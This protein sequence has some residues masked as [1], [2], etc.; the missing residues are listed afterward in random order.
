M[1]AAD[2]RRSVM[3][4]DQIDPEYAGRHPTHG[5]GGHGD[6]QM[7]DG[8]ALPRVLDPVVTMGAV[9]RYVEQER[10]RSR[11]VLVWTSSI[12]LFVILFVLTLF[13]SVG[14]FILKSTR[15]TTD[16]VGNIRAET[17][18]YASEMLVLSNAVDG[19]HGNTVQIRTELQD[20]AGTRIRERRQLQ[21]DLKRFSQWVASQKRDEQNA[22]SALEAKFEGL[23]ESVTAR[24]EE[25]ALLREQNATLLSALAGGGL[26]ADEQQAGQPTPEPETIREVTALAESER[27]PPSP[28]EASRPVA[29]EPAPVPTEPLEPPPGHS[30]ISVVT[31]PSGDRYEG[32][33]HDGLFHGW[34]VYYCRNGDRYEGEFRTDMKAG[35]GTFTYANGD[36]YVGEFRSDMKHGRGSFTYRDGGK[37][38]GDFRDDLPSGK[39]TMV[40]ANGGKYAG[41]FKNGM[42]HGNGAFT[43]PNGDVY[44]GEF[45]EDSRHGRGTYNFMDGAKY[46]GEF[47]NDKRHGK[48]RYIYPGGEEYIGEFKDGKKHG[49]GVCKYPNGQQ[50][51]GLWKN[52]KFV[53]VVES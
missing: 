7:P 51:K 35:R 48:G 39:G 5:Y 8:N 27:P 44:V 12:F 26:N 10:V 36:K 31:F 24:R 4:Q 25:L 16:A 14:L 29:K 1:A 17:A 40:Q 11:R 38:V 43:Y 23:T 32:E 45:G 52:D 6:P 34:G 15:R 47:R 19:L 21:S 33:F 37:Y 13:I 18:L 30:E 50:I 49:Y 3:N 46:V 2:D 53:R 41:D 22:V 42:K 20:R 28:T 9:Q